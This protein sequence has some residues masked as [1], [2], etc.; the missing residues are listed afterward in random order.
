MSVNNI[1]L[2]K[3][4]IYK[5][6]DGMALIHTHFYKNLNSSRYL[7]LAKQYKGY[8]RALHC[9]ILDISQ[10]SQTDI[11]INIENLCLKVINLIDDNILIRLKNHELITIIELQQLFKIDNNSNTYNNFITFLSNIKVINIPINYITD[12][13][14]ICTW[15]NLKI[16]IDSYHYDNDNEKKE[17]YQFCYYNYDK[18]IK[19]VI[20]TVK[21]SKNIRHIHHE[22]GY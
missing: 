9:P 20:Y 17:F 3:V 1:S 7:K 13:A 21:E 18:I 22:H 10:F 4:P 5:N 14:Y 6:K 16:I 19:E 2:D 15:P 12:N 8:F 11:L